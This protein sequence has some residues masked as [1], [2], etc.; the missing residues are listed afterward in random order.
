MHPARPAVDECPVCGRPRCGADADEAPGGGC[1]VCGGTTAAS[2]VSTRL[3]HRPAE[4][5]I[6]AAL[7]AFFVGLLGAPIASEYVGSQGFAEIVPFLLGLVCAAGAAIVA[8]TAGRGRLDVA[9]RV[10]GGVAAVLATAFSFRLVPGGQSP[11]TPLDDVGVPYLCAIAGAAV[12][13][14]FR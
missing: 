3:L 2:D 10:I 5:L 12:S 11:F 6:A 4:R 8:H 13:R 1:L 9:A 14:L 7:V